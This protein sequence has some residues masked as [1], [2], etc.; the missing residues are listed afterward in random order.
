MGGESTNL[1]LPGN[2]SLNAAESPQSATMRVLNSY[3]TSFPPKVTS[4]STGESH[5]QVEPQSANLHD[6]FVPNPVPLD[7]QW[8]SSLD[9]TYAKLNSLSEGVP[10]GADLQFMLLHQQNN[11]RLWMERQE[12]DRQARL[13]STAGGMNSVSGHEMDLIGLEQQ[14]TERYMMDQQNKDNQVHHRLADYQKQLTILDHNR[15]PPPQ[16]ISNEAL[17]EYQVKVASV[18][19]ERKRAHESGQP[20]GNHLLQ[21]YQMQLELLEEQDKKRR[22]VG[23]IGPASFSVFPSNQTG[24]VATGLKVD[25]QHPMGDISALQDYGTQLRLLERHNKR[26][27]ISQAQMRQAAH[28]EAPSD[29][30]PLQNDVKARNLADDDVLT[31]KAAVSCIQPFSLFPI[32]SAYFSGWEQVWSLDTAL[33]SSLILKYMDFHMLTSWSDRRPCFH[34]RTKSL[35]YPINVPNAIVSCTKHFR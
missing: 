24:D 26:R 16:S 13:S 10:E 35:G 14:S 19:A 31:V 1:A 5:S 22:G 2:H 9:I 18:D 17:Q 3:S 25:R 6:P 4:H 34:V 23:R 29:I 20:S 33:G 15:K 12:Q 11:K 8:P 21:D 28:C 32:S 27:R 30:F 7:T